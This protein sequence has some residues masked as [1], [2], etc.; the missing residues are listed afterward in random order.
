[1]Q[2][3]QFLATMP[4]FGMLNSTRVAQSHTSPV[5]NVLKIGGYNYDRVRAISDGTLRI[6]GRRI[7]F[8]TSNIYDLSA[9]AFG[10]E[11]RYDVTEI[12]LIPFLRH[13]ANNGFRAYTLLPV[14]V[15][16][17]FR[18]R[19]IFVR[20][21]SQIETPEDLRG[22]RIGTPSYG[23]SAHTWI[24]GMLAD[25][26]GIQPEEMQWIE[27]T[28]SSDGAQGSEALNRHFLPNDFPLIKG[29]PGVDESDL[30]VS[31]GCDALV[32]AITP[33][34]F[35][36]GD[37]RIRQLFP[38]VKTTEQEYF[39]K[40]GVFP[41]MHALAIRAELAD[42]EPDLLVDLFNLYS[43]AKQMAFAA[44]TETTALR[45][46]LPWA[47]EEFEATR[48]LMGEDYWPYGIA[49]SKNELLLAARY[50]YEQGLTKEP[51]DPLE[52]FHPSVRGVR[53]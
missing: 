51:V 11:Q 37:P 17:T 10:A 40:S 16:R 19:N 45:V 46:S 34:A 33:R 32:T 25:E 35:L 26:Y 22:K 50:A 3:R 4:A 49:T 41:I 43:A 28:E 23:F 44:L 2:R 18:H 12:G 30:L 8:E 20:S 52:L 38:D 15:S 29:P 9:S 14:F 39:R 47:V 7:Q 53:E 1:M 27:T 24:R 5:S 13:Y 21:D 6:P 31:G 42:A 36:E 48:M